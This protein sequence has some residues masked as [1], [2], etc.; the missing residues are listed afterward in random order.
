MDYKKHYDMLIAKGKNRVLNGYKERHHIVPRCMGGT[1]DIE[2]KVDLTPEEHYLAHLLL[3]KIYPGNIKLVIS[4]MYLTSSNKNI[5]RN[6]K[7]YGW[8]KR[9]WS[10]YMKGPSNPGKNQPTGK[11]HWKYGIP[12]DKTCFTSEVL[13]LIAASKRGDKN[14]NYGIKPWNHGRATNYTK[15]IWAK[16]DEIKIIWENNNKPSYAKLYSL[17]NGKSYGKDYEAIGP[18]MNL[19]KYFRKNWEPAEDGEW[20]IFKNS[21]L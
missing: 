5:P 9:K 17:I 1:D 10:N 11:D 19:V 15:S 3:V 12:F 2:N 4:A 21:F 20:N 6:N 16:A 7:T 8:L 13:E 14:P 18:Y